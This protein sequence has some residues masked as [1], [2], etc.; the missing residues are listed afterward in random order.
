MRY[1]LSDA[2][3]DHVPLQSEISYLSQYIELQ[4]L[5]LTDKVTIIYEVTGDTSSHLIAPLILVPFIENAFKFGISTHEPSTISILIEVKGNLLTMKVA[6]KL[7]P[8][9]NLIAKSSGIGLVNV[10][11][12]LSLLYPDK[13]RLKLDPD[14]DGQYIVALEIN[15]SV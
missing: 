5:R 14:S 4:K 3:N 2:Q 13:Y 6:N 7:F 8:R 1:V 9:T 10:K 12:R 15:L 11:R